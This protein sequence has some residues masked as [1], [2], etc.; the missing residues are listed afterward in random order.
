[1]PPDGVSWSASTRVSWPATRASATSHSGTAASPRPARAAAR[2]E[3]WL[4][5]LDD[6]D[7]EVEAVL[8]Q[9]R[10]GR[11]LDELDVDGGIAREEGAQPR[12]DIA[13]GESVRCAD[14]QPSGRLLLC[15]LGFAARA[16]QFVE[17]PAAVAVESHAP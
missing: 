6:A 7:G 5:L 10:G 14:A 9:I 1:M 13:L 17:Q 8:D 11:C 15:R 4:G 12:D 2:H 16:C 3:A